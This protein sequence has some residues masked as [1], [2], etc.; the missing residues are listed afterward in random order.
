M[1][2]DKGGVA[3]VV[4]IPFRKVKVKDHG[5]PTEAE[6]RCQPRSARIEGKRDMSALACAQR[7]K[8]LKRKARDPM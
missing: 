4:K 1:Q 5:Q 7:K 2:G 3:G 8:K 6:K